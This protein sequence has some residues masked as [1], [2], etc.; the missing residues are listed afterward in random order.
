MGFGPKNVI[1]LI[2]DGMGYNQVD[3]GSLY[4]N[5][6]SFNQVRVDP[7]TGKIEHEPGTASQVYENFP[8]RLG[9]A[10][11]Q[12]RNGYEPDKA[13]GD[14]AWVLKNPPDSAATATAMATGVRTYNGA[15]GLDPDRLPVRNLTERAQELGKAS[16][17]VTS[18]QFSH[19]TPAAFV[20]HNESRGNYRQI[21]REMVWEHELDVLM[22]AGHPYFDD[23]GQARDTPDFRY[24]DEAT[25]EAAVSGATGHT[26]IEKAGDFAD[27]ADAF[28]PPERVFGLP[29]VART[30]QFHRSGP[31]RDAD[32]TPVE[33]AEPYTAPELRTVPSLAEMASGALNVLDN[34]SDRGMFLM[35]E[36]GAIDWGGHG[37]EMGRM[38]EEQLAFNEAIETVVDWVERESSW[39]ET[40]VVVTADHET[41]YLAGPGAGAD[42]GWTPLRGEAGGL[43]EHSWHTGGHTNSLV[44]LYAKG[45][46]ASRIDH[47]ARHT[48]PVRGDYLENVKLAESVF[49]FWGR[50]DTASP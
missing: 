49:D 45:P 25:Y 50:G 8:V 12:H 34:A 28:D 29:Q 1:F 36:G 37:N 44:P 9:M 10:T 17:V 5:G 14:F 35:V 42:T 3:A 47:H 40:L 48:D 11:Y 27:L 23:D 18:V 6:T 38:I 26:F 7:E 16:G 32:G 39:Q 19:A 31:D 30:L 43:P 24:I 21:A 22:G 15:I 41:G 13:W 20:A 4:E 33:G 2:G 46:G